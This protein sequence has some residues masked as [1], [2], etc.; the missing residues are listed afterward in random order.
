MVHSDKI[1]ICM[2]S[3]EPM[4]IVERNTICPDE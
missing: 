1:E 4:L 2:L 3:I